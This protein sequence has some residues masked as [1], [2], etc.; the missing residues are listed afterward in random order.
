MQIVSSAPFQSTAFRQLG[1]DGRLSCV[2]VLKATFMHRQGQYPLIAS[3][4]VPLVDA[5]VY[6][7]GGDPQHVPLTTSTDFVPSKP[8]TD[9]VF[10]EKS[11]SPD[12]TACAQ[13]QAS[14][15]VG[16]LKKTILVHGRR[17]WITERKAGLSRLLSKSQSWQIAPQRDV[18]SVTIDW[19]NTVGEWSGQ[20]QT[21]QFN[22]FNPIGRTASPPDDLDEVRELPAITTENG[23]LGSPAGFG[24]L[25]PFYKGRQQKGCKVGDDRRHL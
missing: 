15:E 25:A 18:D 24:P 22:A 3:E 17:N 12:G 4:Q 11:H 23:Q 8:G 20:D 13:W 10:L 14:L 2:V 1:Q 7:G 21:D 9:V 5:D 6:E 16:S 19:R